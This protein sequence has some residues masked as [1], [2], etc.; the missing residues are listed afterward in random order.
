MTVS[1]HT[2]RKIYSE[3]V[4]LLFVNSTVP[5]IFSTLAAA[6][7]CWLFQTSI[8]QNVLIAW[9]AIFFTI[10]A[11][12]IA[13]IALFRKQEARSSIN[14]W[15]FIFLVGTYAHALIWGSASFF[16]F[17]EHNPSHQIVFFMIM[18]GAAVAAIASLCPS[19]PAIDIMVNTRAK[20]TC[21]PC[22]RG[23]S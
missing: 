13:L 4:H 22:Q 10:S 16:L 15:H 9:L 21:L 14:L 20:K 2:S 3:Q 11:G 19:L 1:K 18:A 23:L 6:L 8:S 12:R 7:L 17:P 5:I